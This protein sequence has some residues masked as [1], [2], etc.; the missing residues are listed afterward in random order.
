[1]KPKTLVTR[2]PPDGTIPSVTLMI[3]CSQARH[4]FNQ[5]PLS[6]IRSNVELLLMYKAAD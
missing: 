4:F 2:Q 5:T 1:M 3:V 6:N